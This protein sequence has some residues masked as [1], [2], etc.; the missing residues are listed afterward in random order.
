MKGI[1]IDDG[2]FARSPVQPSAQHVTCAVDAYS[3]N[4]SPRTR[5]PLDTRPIPPDDGQRF[6]Q[7]V[8]S[9]F[10][11]ARHP[12]NRSDHLILDWHDQRIEV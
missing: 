6:L 8:F 3:Q 2:L 7:S 1:G 12:P 11:N 9:V 5:M 10:G 4:Q